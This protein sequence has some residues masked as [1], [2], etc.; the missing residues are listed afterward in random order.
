MAQLP[1]LLGVASFA[2]CLGSTLVAQ[3]LRAQTAAA[4][5]PAAAQ[6]GAA[7]GPCESLVVVR[8]AARNGTGPGTSRS[9]PGLDS[10]RKA[11]VQARAAW[12]AGPS[13]LEE[14]VILG[15]RSMSRLGTLSQLLQDAAAPLPGMSFRTVQNADGTRC[16]CA[17]APCVMNCCVCS[18][19]R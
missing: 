11:L 8:C 2:V 13:D 19:R 15:E 18:P 10:A 5:A 3:P 14:I 9:K 17:S 7:F 4:R 1:A 12:E 6:D 16:T